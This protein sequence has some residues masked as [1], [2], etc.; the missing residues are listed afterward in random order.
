MARIT[1]V[2]SLLLL[3]RIVQ[4]NIEILWS[5]HL[6]LRLIYIYIYIYI[7]ISIYIYIY[8]Y[9]YIYFYLFISSMTV[10]TLFWFST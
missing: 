3:S 2:N 6:R 4:V 5:T 10:I 8:I 1:F 9:K 7:Y